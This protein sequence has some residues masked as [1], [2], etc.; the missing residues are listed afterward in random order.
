[1]ALR[2]ERPGNQ[3]NWLVLSWNKKR[4]WALIIL[5]FT[6]IKQVICRQGAYYWGWRLKACVRFFP[7]QWE[8]RT[9]YLLLIVCDDWVFA[10]FLRFVLDVRSWFE[11][12][13][14]LFIFIKVAVCTTHGCTLSDARQARTNAAGKTCVFSLLVCFCCFFFFCKSA[15]CLMMGFLN[16]FICYYLN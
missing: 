2:L 15:K 14:S 11:L 7:L 12:S 3:I 4:S 16:W 8:K 9:L 1:M 13:D 10:K 5:V 6:K